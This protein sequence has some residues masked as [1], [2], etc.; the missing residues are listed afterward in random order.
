M[1]NNHWFI[2]GE[3]NNNF[4]YYSNKMY[5]KEQENV[6]M[7]YIDHFDMGPKFLRNT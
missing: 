7:A 1:L 4:Q 3:H 5:E 2:V 6:D